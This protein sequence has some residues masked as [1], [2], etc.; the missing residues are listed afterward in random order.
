MADTKFIY[1]AVKL[2]DE[3]DIHFPPMGPNFDVRLL[4]IRCHRT[5]KKSLANK[6]RMSNKSNLLPKDQ[7]IVDVRLVIGPN[8]L[9]IPLHEEGNL[10]LKGEFQ[11]GREQKKKIG[12]E[13]Q[14]KELDLTHTQTVQI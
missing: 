7:V 5:E 2:A 8:K 9:R 4:S 13:R 12:G 3:I 14:S 11:V 10:D 1:G 6:M